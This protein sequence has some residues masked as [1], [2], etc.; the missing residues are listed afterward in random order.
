M[1]IPFDWNTKKK[2]SPFNGAIGD[3]K[4]PFFDVKICGTSCQTFKTIDERVR[5]CPGGRSLVVDPQSDVE[6]M[7]F[8]Q[9]DTAT[10]IYDY[11]GDAANAGFYC[12]N[13]SNVYLAAPMPTKLL[14]KGQGTEWCRT[15]QWGRKGY[16]FPNDLETLPNCAASFNVDC[17]LV[18][19]I[20]MMVAT[21]AEE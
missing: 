13:L 11:K 12:V 3:V 4:E 10:D 2:F 21:E 6:D 7:Q 8:I 18:P 19:K 1:S 9:P 17:K 20:N 14:A 15:D 16:C 5:V